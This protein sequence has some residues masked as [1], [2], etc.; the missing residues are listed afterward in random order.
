MNKPE[1]ELGSFHTSE[2]Q[3]EDG[4]TT[5]DV[6]YSTPYGQELVAEPPSQRCAEAVADALNLVRERLLDCGSDR[7][8]FALMQRLYEWRLMK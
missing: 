7:E 4:S 6:Y 2:N 8:V 5:H 1:Y 3:L